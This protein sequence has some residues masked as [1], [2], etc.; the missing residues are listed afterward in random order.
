[1]KFAVLTTLIAIALPAPAL[2]ADWVLVGANVSGTEVYVDLQSI[3]TMPN[4]YK[5]AWRRF[6]LKIPDKD[7]DDVYTAYQ[8][9][10]CVEK[11]ARP[12]SKIFRNGEQVTYTQNAVGEWSYASPDSVAESLLIFVCRK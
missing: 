1:M 11:R 2:A 9:F 6:D 7:G 5:R 4:G 8:E 12:L 3:R 10:D